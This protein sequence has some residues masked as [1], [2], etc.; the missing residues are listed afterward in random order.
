MH[1]PTQHIFPVDTLYMRGRDCESELDG[2]DFRHREDGEFREGD[3]EQNDDDGCGDA[4]LLFEDAAS[5]QIFYALVCVLQ[6]AMVCYLICMS[7]VASSSPYTG[8]A[9]NL[10]HI[11]LATDILCVDVTSA[12][13]VL[14]GFLC[15]FVYHSV[16]PEVW[17]KI[18]AQMLAAIFIDLWIAGVTAVLIGSL[19][20]LIKHRFK[21]VDIPFTLFEHVTAVR[22]FDVR[23]AP[24]A[25]H[26]LNVSAWP[27]MCSVWCLMSVASTFHTNN[28]LRGHLGA[29]GKYAIMV[30]AVMGVVLFTLFGMLHS[31]SNIFYANATAFTYRTLEFNLGIHFFYLLDKN[32]AIVTN[33]LTLVHQSSPGII[34][35]FVCIWWSEIGNEVVLVNTVAGSGDSGPDAHMV[36]LRMFPRN[37]CL[38]DHH[39]FLL[40][41]CFL[42]ITLISLFAYENSARQAYG[43]SGASKRVLVQARVCVSAVAFAWPVYLTVQFIFQI[44][45]GGDL[46]NRN[47]PLMSVLQTTFLL[48]SATLY[49][50]FVKPQLTSLLLEAVRNARSGPPAGAS[51]D[52]E[53]S[54]NFGS[55]YSG[56]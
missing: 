2:G 19:D 17:V 25:P 21:F 52:V 37:N 53:L 40:R 30:F 7:F 14:G 1:S 32:D 45:F 22:L 23:Q 24:E 36:C 4:V 20:A 48:A 41:G 56:P 51:E 9:S 55:E 54:S 31:R 46:V 8:H 16:G 42:G 47:M 5:E 26:S 49:T 38:R 29:V 12:F 13:F 44:T 15:G 27:V 34:F 10:D 39:A 28:F 3:D 50:L 18:R 6:R 33:L 11:M 35:V 43:S